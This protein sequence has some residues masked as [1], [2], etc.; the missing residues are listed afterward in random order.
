MSFVRE[1]SVRPVSVL[2]LSILIAA[3][4]GSV[5]AELRLEGQL[6]SVS[7]EG[8]G[9]VGNN[10]VPGTR[11]DLES[12][13]GY[14]DEELIFGG[15][16]LWGDRHQVGGSFFRIDMSASTTFDKVVKFDNII[17]PPGIDVQSSLEATVLRGFYRYSAGD[18]VFRVGP[19]AGFQYLDLSSRASSLQI[20]SAS[21][22]ITTPMPILGAFF[23]ATATDW[24]RFQLSGVGISWDFDDVSASFYDIEAFVM[25]GWKSYF[26][27]GGY[28][29]VVI[30]GEDDTEP[31]DADITFT[32][33]VGMFGA[34]W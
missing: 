12:D 16:V 32:G 9:A 22:D 7:V 11:L 6:W 8:D 27:A 1:S 10:G 31:T 3:A 14:T 28:R 24:L 26:L 23:E 20:G 4:T 34:R 2:V 25:V 13:L 33:P 30:D 19:I 5:R 15:T 17:F 29:R 21:A 18:D